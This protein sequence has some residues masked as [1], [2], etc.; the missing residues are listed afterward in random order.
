[1]K[2]SDVIYQIFPRNYSKEG[3]FKQIELDLNRIKSL[4]VDIIYL[5]PIH[6]IGIKNRKGTYGSPYA[7]KDY[8]SI[9]PDLGTKEDLISL[10][11]K[12]HALGMK[13]ILDM[14]FN[15]TSPDNILLPEHDKYYFHRNGRLANKVGDWSDIVDLDTFRSDTQDYLLSVLKYWVSL[16]IDGF[17]FDVCSLIDFSFFIKARKE[18]GK[19]IIFIGESIDRN[20]ANY[21]KSEHI[22][23]KDDKDL[24]E[25]FDSLYNYHI[26]PS[27]M[28]YID[29][30]I[31]IQEIVD[32][33]N[34]D[35]A[36]QRLLC[37]EN[38]DRDRISSILNKEE[39]S[40]YLD[41]FS[42]IKGNAFIYAGQEYGNKH[43]PELFEKDPVDFSNKDNDIFNLYINYINKKKTQRE[44]IKQEF[45]KVDNQTIKVVVTYLDKT[46]E[47][48][49]I[50][51]P[52][53]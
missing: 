10:I 34:E 24:Y 50:P 18:L 11:N 8:F 38:H 5:L 15:H 46:K 33:L 43:K 42:F 31:D 28:S 47:E 27:L 44:I 26:F 21:L 6:E 23:V 22:Y 17:R 37:L 9:S 39:L 51:L 12:T 41:F 25:V 4:N 1:M 7:I 2:T 14:V 35:N 40:K 30:K 32:I 53:K 29:G 36:N 49:N 48:R 19:D 45:F 3:N 16:G 20:F 52:R 13:I